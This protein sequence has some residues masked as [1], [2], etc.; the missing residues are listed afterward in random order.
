MIRAMAALVLSKYEHVLIVAARV[1]QLLA[2]APRMVDDADTQ[3]VVDIAE[4]EIA[5]RVLPI[6]I[7]RRL[8]NGKVRVYDLHAFM[9]ISPSPCSTAVPIVVALPETLPNPEEPARTLPLASACGG[10]RISGDAQA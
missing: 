4:R 9:D 8:P 2:G 3:D 5:R 10:T 7:A 6:R 1:E